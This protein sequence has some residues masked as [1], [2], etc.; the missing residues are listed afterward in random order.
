MAALT[1]VR[2]TSELGG[3]YI[4]L[5]V[6][7]A[8]TIYQVPSWRLTPTA[9]RSPARRRP[10]QGSGRAEETVETR[11]ATARPSSASL[12]ASSSSRTPPAQDRRRRSPGPVLHRGRP[13]RHE[14][15]RRAPR[16]PVSSFASTTKASPS[17]WAS[18][19]PRDGWRWRLIHTDKEE[20]EHDCQSAVLRGIYVGFNTLFNRAFEGVTPLYTQIATTT[21][22][23]TDSETYAWLGDIPGMREWIGDREIQNLS[24][25]DYTIKNKDFELTVGVDRNAIEDDKIGLY[26]PSARCSASPQ[27]LIPTSSSSPCWRAAS[28][29]SATTDS[30]FLRRPQ[31][32]KEDRHQQEHR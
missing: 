6:K 9:T 30:L 19:T 8:T 22:S 21:P 23:T 17:R 3:K 20:T 15:R 7:G 32:R 16:S 29:K 11:E 4:A 31:D 10:P 18:A 27:Q 28:R 26:N 12:A 2:D 14:D 13:D 25:S 24:A 1:N 5:P